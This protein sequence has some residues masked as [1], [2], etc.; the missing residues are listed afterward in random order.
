[1]ILV[2][3]SRHD[4]VARALVGRWAAHGARLL[5]SAD[6]SAAGWR[7]HSDAAGTS[8]LL[9]GGRVIPAREVSGVLT[10]LPCVFERELVRIAPVHRAYVAAEM[11][12][13]LTFWLSDLPCPVLNRPTPGC[14]AGPNWRREQWVHAAARAGIPVRSVRR[15][16]GVSAGLSPEAPYP[17][18]ITVTVVGDRCVGRVTRRLAAQARHLADTARLDLLAVRFSGPGP[19]AHFVDADPWPDI[20]ADP[21]VTDAVIEYLQKGAAL[22]PQTSW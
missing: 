4:L 8:T 9:V 16:V 20:A 18:P 1:M 19:G 6:L 21:A 5:T 17:H 14:L 11:T 22:C 15:C 12:A 3:A 2:I 7:H 10:R 13:F